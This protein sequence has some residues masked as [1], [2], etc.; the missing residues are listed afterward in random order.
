MMADFMDE[1]INPRMR[2]LPLRVGDVEIKVEYAK[3][4]CITKNNVHLVQGLKQQSVMVDKYKCYKS[5]TVLQ[6][7]DAL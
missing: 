5:L 6:H 4:W 1:D 2:I 3:F 7:I